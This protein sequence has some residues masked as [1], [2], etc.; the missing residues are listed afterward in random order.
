MALHP[1]QRR[2]IKMFEIEVR[3]KTDSDTSQVIELLQQLSKFTTNSGDQKLLD[4]NFDS[5]NFK[6]VVIHK[7][8]NKIIA[9][10]HLIYFEKFRGGLVGLIED[11]VVDEK[12]RRRGIGGLIISNLQAH[13]KEFGAFK[14]MLNSEDV[15][16]NFYK[17]NGFVSQGH[18]LKKLI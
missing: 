4:T 13:A 16:L 2:R 11:I 8:S 15:N 5:K 17:E 10:A 14:L 9:F 6:F 3:Q 1:T 7:P 12:F 18:S